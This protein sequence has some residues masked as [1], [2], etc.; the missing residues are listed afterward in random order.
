MSPIQ[1]HQMLCVL[2]VLSYTS[3]VLYV[4]SQGIL[5]L[6]DIGKT[7]EAFQTLAIK[8]LAARNMKICQG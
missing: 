3:Q 4:I 6:I 1:A 7:L 5:V 8:I 2:F